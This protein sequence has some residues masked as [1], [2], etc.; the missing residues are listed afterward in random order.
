MSSDEPFSLSE[1][2]KN[3]ERVQL[4]EIPLPDLPVDANTGNNA[5]SFAFIILSS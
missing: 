4:N 1:Q 3:A 5:L 2:V